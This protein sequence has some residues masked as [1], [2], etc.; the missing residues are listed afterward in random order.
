MD[1]EQ[2]LA[3][4]SRDISD[5]LINS[6]FLL[7]IL[8]EMAMSDAKIGTMISVIKNNITSAFNDIEECRH[9]IFILD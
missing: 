3:E 7:E 5:K 2:N 8:E 1:K 9:K 6:K 4:L